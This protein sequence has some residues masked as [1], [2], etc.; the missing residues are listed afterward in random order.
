MQKGHFPLEKRP[1]FAWAYY[2]TEFLFCQ[3]IS[4]KICAEKAETKK[5]FLGIF[6][7]IHSL[8]PVPFPPAQTSTKPRKTTATAIHPA[9]TAPPFDENIS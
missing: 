2:G 6:S 9:N 8:F 1:R 5:I 3:M 4:A 7:Q